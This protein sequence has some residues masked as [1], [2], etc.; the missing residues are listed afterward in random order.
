VEGTGGLVFEGNAPSSQPAG[1]MFSQISSAAEAARH[2]GSDFHLPA[3][4]S[5]W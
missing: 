5:V 2:R 1:P 3:W 4:N